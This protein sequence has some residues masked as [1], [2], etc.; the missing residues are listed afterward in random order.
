[1]YLVS[2][3]TPPQLC[4]QSRDGKILT[5]YYLDTVQ[6]QLQQLSDFSRLLQVMLHTQNDHMEIS[7]AKNSNIKV[8]TEL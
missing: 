1:M 6:K 2:I 8:V 7:R 4:L 5:P 3:N